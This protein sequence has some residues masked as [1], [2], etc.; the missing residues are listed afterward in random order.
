M[1]IK[2]SKVIFFSKKLYY[3]LK[4]IDLSTR[5]ST[6]TVFFL[7]RHNEISY[8]VP[9]ENGIWN[10]EVVFPSL[11]IKASEFTPKIKI[12]MCKIVHPNL[13]GLISS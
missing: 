6:Q 12:N 7:N 4:L 13:E 1:Y 5:H 2:E 8:M 11:S 3:A 9:K 10:L